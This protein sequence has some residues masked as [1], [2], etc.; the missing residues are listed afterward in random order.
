MRYRIVKII[1]Y[2]RLILNVFTEFLAN[3]GKKNQ[4]KLNFTFLPFCLHSYQ[5]DI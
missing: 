1:A 5:I 2:L 3:D 4:Q